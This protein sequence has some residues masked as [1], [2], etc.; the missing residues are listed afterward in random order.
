[1]KN[2]R[3]IRWVALSALVVW[4]ASSVWADV[5]VKRQSSTDGM[6]GLLK[7]T[8]T[9]T[10]SYSGDKM[11][12]DSETK[13]ENKM[14]KMFGGGKPVRSTSITRLD[15]EV[16]WNL[17]HKDKKY[18]EMTFA[19]MRA[20]MDSL[21]SMM[22]NASDPMAQQ[23]PEIDTSEITF[24]PPK[25][26][27][28][29]TG[30]RE[31]IAGYECDQAVMTMTT[32]GTN[33][34]TGETM[35][36]ELV[37]DMMLAQNVAGVNEITDFGVRMAKAIGFSADQSSGQ[38]MN[39][40][41]SMYGI[42]AERLAEEAKKLEGFA[43]KS[44]MSFSMGG[45]AMDKAKA[46]ADAE[47]AQ[48]EQGQQEEEEQA[49]KDEETPSDASG[50]AAK[51]LG[52]LFGKKEKTK[53]AEKPK[54]EAASEAPPGAMLWITTTVTGIESGSVPAD[55]FEVPSEYKLEKTAMQKE[56]E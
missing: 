45:D 25:F 28:K 46:D 33:R 14:V 34:K 47:K 4:S 54:E 16:I 50:M 44:V 24:A 6:G 55:R 8:T 43:M 11:A 17:D 21:G 10:E 51:A 35:T 27:V 26:D 13:M 42:D 48:R 41:L 39:K 2:Q 30:K 3:M 29:K 15:K 5:T 31:T 1:M 38:S 19:E 12:N 9:S 23:K 18:S 22:S 37:M 36:L 52:G 7:A 20:L 32:V 40:M 49:K 56:N 53:D